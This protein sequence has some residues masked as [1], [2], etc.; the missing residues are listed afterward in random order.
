MAIDSCISLLQNSMVR[1]AL[2][3]T[4]SP[5][6]CKESDMTEHAPNTHPSHTYLRKSPKLWGQKKMG[7]ATSGI[8]QT[9]SV[10]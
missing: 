4:Y 8:R 5:W 3:A 1:R 7:L 9:G 10:S 6:G 2:W